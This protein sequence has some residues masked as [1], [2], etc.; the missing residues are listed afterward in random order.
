MSGGNPWVERNRPHEGLVPGVANEEAE[1]PRLRRSL[2]GL[3]TTEEGER[4]L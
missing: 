2:H 1:N 4:I 3:D